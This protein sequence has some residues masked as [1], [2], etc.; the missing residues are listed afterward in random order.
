MD[1]AKRD[2]GARLLAGGLC[3][4]GYWI[5]LL[6]S[7]AHAYI[8]P[9]AGGL[10]L[11]ALLA[12]TAGIVLLVR[13]FWRRSG[14]FRKRFRRMTDFEAAPS[15][16]RR[17][18]LSRG[19]KIYRPS[20]EADRNHAALEASGLLEKMIEAD[21]SSPRGAPPRG[22]PPAATARRSWR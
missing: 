6:A 1:F 15:A 8:D 2:G 14:F 9:T 17:A 7:P 11:Q 13:L 3:V 22:A 20:P 19:R 21:K 4:V 5:A 10:L 12:G 18:G 16:I